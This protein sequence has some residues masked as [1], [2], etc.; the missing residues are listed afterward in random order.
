M[1]A[2]LMTV[3]TTKGYLATLPLVQALWWFIE[4]VPTEHPHASE[5]FFLL[6]KRMR[7]H[8]RLTDETR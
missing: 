8:H 7:E 6:R 1:N 2:H 5:L 4:N 3:R